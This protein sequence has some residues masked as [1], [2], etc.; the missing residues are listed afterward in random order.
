MK[1]RDF[2]ALK[3]GEILNKMNAAVAANDSEAFTEAF[4]ELCQEIEQ[5]VL[6]QAKELVNQNDMNVLAQ[7]GVRQLTS[8]E[9]EYYEKII[10]AMKSQDPKQALNN[11]ETV[12]PET[13]INSV[14]EDL[15]TN[16]PLLSKLNATSVSGLTRMMMNT[17]GEQKAAW[18]KLTSKIIEELTSGFKEVDVTQDKLSAFLPVSKAMLDLGPAW[19]DNY[20]RQVLTEAL[21]NG[22]EYGIVNGTGKDEPIG[23]SRQV[24]DGVNVVSGEYPKK[25]TIKITALNM[26]QLGNITSIMARNSNGQART[27]SNLI[28]IVNPVD[29]WKRI[30]PATR[31][32][33]PDGVYVSTLPIPVEIIQSAAVDEGTAV[34][35][36]AGKY[37]LGIGM[38]KNGKIEY[39]DE[40]RFLEDERVYLIKA[41]A[42][43]F[44]L[45]N[46]AFVVL[47]I[48][49]LQPVRFEVVSKLEEHVDNALLSD[50]KIGG[51]TLT[52]KFDAST[53]SYKVTTTAATNTITAFPESATATIEIKTG[54]VPVTNGGKATWNSGSNTVT[55]KVTDGEQTKTYTVTV[56]KE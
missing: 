51:L 28:M 5:N 12:F 6:E 15:T 4:M 1:N 10:D 52:P 2:I 49:D 55:V 48:K 37:F 24:G 43:G 46:N 45:D 3:R 56:T 35:G 20:V 53:V 27:V 33:S 11:I 25:D 14:F 50:L 9:R 41:Y 8:A 44:A 34:Y 13:I 21:A 29:Y 30:L 47:N 54:E 39:S 36:L 40:Y 17:N 16:H 23:M 7:R 38:A 42:Y 18:G 31:A 26:V 22:L 32:M 19:L